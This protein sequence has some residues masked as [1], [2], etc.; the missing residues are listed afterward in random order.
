MMQ[1]TIN[2]S[3]IHVPKTIHSVLELI[4]Y[5]KINSQFII[6]EQNYRILKKEDYAQAIVTNGDQFEFVQFVGGG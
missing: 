1:L 4:Q 2:G 3:T 5:L 6:V